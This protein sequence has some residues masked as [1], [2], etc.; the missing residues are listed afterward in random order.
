[1]SERPVILLCGDLVEPF[2]KTLKRFNVLLKETDTLQ[3]DYLIFGTYIYVFSLFEVTLNNSLE[4]IL[5]S[6]PGKIRLD[7]NLEKKELINTTII[8]NIVDGRAT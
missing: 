4:Y 1:M 2:N 5:K 7:F 3:K 6:I 8:Q